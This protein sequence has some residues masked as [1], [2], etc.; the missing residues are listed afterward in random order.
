MGVNNLTSTG[1]FNSNSKIRVA[2]VGDSIT[3]GDGTQTFVSLKREVKGRNHRERGSYPKVLKTMLA[4]AQPGTFEVGM[5]AVGGT[6]ALQPNHLSAE[7]HACRKDSREA[8]AC[9]FTLTRAFENALAF[10]PQA[11]LLLLGTND[12]KDLEDVLTQHL[13]EDVSSLI[14][15]FRRAM[16]LG[17]KRNIWLLLPPRVWDSNTHIKPVILEDVIR[18]ILQ[19]AAEVERVPTIDLRAP[20]DEDP[21]KFI[22]SQYG[23]HHTRRHLPRGDGIHPTRAG[24]ALIAETVLPHLLQSFPPRPPTA[25][26][27]KRA[28]A[29]RRLRGLNQPGSRVISVRRAV[30]GARMMPNANRFGNGTNQFMDGDIDDV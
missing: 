15:T 26:E 22:G 10:R 12:A 16:P 9:S 14:K 23:P 4:E 30:R 2:C 19:G 25:F 5:F 13:Q 8:E 7:R 1:R 20:F 29:N 6:T 27:V 21:A 3:Y 28:E 11:V 18:P 24:S 17:Y